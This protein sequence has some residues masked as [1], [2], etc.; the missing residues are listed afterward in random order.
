MS[1][2]K[3]LDR[4]Q[5]LLNLSSSSNAN[6]AA[7]AMAKAQEL[8]REH[9][10]TD[11]DLKAHQIA[12]VKIKSTQ[13]VS[14]PKD[15]ELSLVWVCAKAFGAVVLWQPGHSRGWDYKLNKPDY[16]GRFHLVGEKSKIPLAEYAV[17]VLL[18][19]LVKERTAFAKKLADQ[20][21]ARGAVMT[22]HLDGFCK[23][24]IATVHKKVSTFANEP[25]IQQLI[26]AR[27]KLEITRPDGGEPEMAKVDD[28][29][30]SWAG[31]AAG[32]LAAKDVELNRPMGHTET[33]RIK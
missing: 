10:L 13:S 28:R 22:A 11:L 8:M 33:L 6:E 21:H 29:G 20:G 4:I 12:D 7:A 9:A 14:K 17:V 27:V 25:E 26:D 5:K 18:R 2:E 19:Q 1:N 16:W 32:R 23:G 15:W 30:A 24:W 31:V 3:L